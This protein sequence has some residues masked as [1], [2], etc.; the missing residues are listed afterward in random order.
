MSDT[1]RVDAALADDAKTG[2][3]SITIV[4]L[5][6]QLERE[7]S[8]QA[9][10]WVSVGERLPEVGEQVLVRGWGERRKHYMFG[11]A[12]WEKTLTGSRWLGAAPSDSDSE[13]WFAPVDWM[14]LPPAPGNGGEG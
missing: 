1:P 8:A 14:P 7:L 4:E 5:A 9:G 12:K 11:L 10:R 3:I 13:F 2:M 6:R